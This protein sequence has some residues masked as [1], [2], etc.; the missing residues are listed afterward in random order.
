MIIVT[1]TSIVYQHPEIANAVWGDFVPKALESGQ[2]KAKP[3]PLVIKGGLKEAQHGLDR[4]KQGVS[5]AKV[6][7]QL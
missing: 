7:V 3:D 1:S 6:V 5:A 4:Q 2:L